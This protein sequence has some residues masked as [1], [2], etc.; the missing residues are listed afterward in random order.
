[1]DSN[2]NIETAQY[3]SVMHWFIKANKRGKENSTVGCHYG[4]HE[5]GLQCA[6]CETY[7]TTHLIVQIHTPVELL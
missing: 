5:F 1:M 7:A 2:H 3:I 6:L 4:R